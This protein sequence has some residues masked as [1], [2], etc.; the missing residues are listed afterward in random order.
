ME[1][2]KFKIQKFNKVFNRIIIV[3]F[4][5]VLGSHEAREKETLDNGKKLF[6]YCR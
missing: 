4:F 6:L 5:C 1:I 3:A 2:L